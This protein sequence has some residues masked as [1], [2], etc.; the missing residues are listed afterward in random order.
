MTTPP[1]NERPVLRGPER[2]TR[3]QDRRSAAN[4][5]SG[6]Q[7]RRPASQVQ[8]NG[9]NARFATR[10]MAFTKGLRHD[11]DGVAD[12]AA[13]A[14]YV[15]ALTAQATTEPLQVMSDFPVPTA[16]EAYA[17]GNLRVSCTP[18]PVPVTQPPAKPRGPFRKWESPLA[19]LYFENQGPDPDGVG[20]P[21]APRFGSSELCAEMAEVYAMAVTRD[22]GLSDLAN[23]ATEL[24]HI[25]PTDGSKVP[26]T[27]AQADGGTRPATVADLVDALASLSWFDPAKTPIGG[28]TMS[29][30]L[31]SHEMRRRSA[32]WANGTSALTAGALFRGSSRGCFDGP[33]LSQFLLIGT[34]SRDGQQTAADGYVRFGAQVVDQRVDIARPGLDY[35]TTWA[36]WLDVQNG[37]NLRGT[38]RFDEGRRFMVSGRDLS[39]YVHFDQLY[40]AYFNAALL[41]LEA[42]VGPDKGLPD[43]DQPRREGFATFGGP[44][45][46]SL[47]TE[48]ATRGLRAVRRQ[49]FQHHRRARPERLAAMITHAANGHSAAIGNADHWMASVL[50]ELGLAPGSE[51]RPI[52]ILMDWVDQ[53]N[54]RQN[55]PEVR[56]LRGYDCKPV[57]DPPLPEPAPGWNYLLP[58]AFPE[59]SPMHPAYGA[60]HATVAG[61]CVTILKAFFQLHKPD[62]QMAPGDEWSALPMDSCHGLHEIFVATADGSGLWTTGGPGL[63]IE[64]EL[65]KLAANIAIGR[66]IA[67]VHFY[68]D[69]YE[70]VRLGERVAIGI[71]EEQMYSYAEDVTMHLRSFDGDQITIERK[72]GR[73]ETHI[74]DGNMAVV[75]MRDWWVRHFDEYADAPLIA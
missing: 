63:T 6:D 9:D 47:L 62:S 7:G 52:R 27:M 58:V 28:M 36:E 66:D 24:Y 72:G 70:S 20:M 54:A 11:A 41:M 26:Y 3:A 73:V 55:Q 4:A 60:G 46:L 10:L 12:P 5:T 61:A 69:Y 64:G 44:H 65:N 56:Q 34:G 48:V 23:P 45:L 57:A 16:A 71:L 13:Y 68:T 15:N 17:A 37:V 50:R 25:D 67:G 75:H 1:I 32:R 18:R 38:D 49:K 14:A 35:M 8:S 2:A 21:P 42:G 31:T 39:T 59:G 51:D 74:R 53:L 22:M 19:G 40:Q 30:A 33:Y 43:S 29:N